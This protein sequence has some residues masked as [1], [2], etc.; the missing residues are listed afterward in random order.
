VLEGKH[1]DF[2]KFICAEDTKTLFLINYAFM[3]RKMRI[4]SNWLFEAQVLENGKIVGRDQGKI[5][6]SSRNA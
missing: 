6:S 2:D 4:T 5:S 3:D 1:E